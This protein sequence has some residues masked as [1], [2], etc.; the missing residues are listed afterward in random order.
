MQGATPTP[1]EPFRRTG[2]GH[3]LRLTLH[4]VRRELTASHRFTMLG[5]LWPLLRLLAQ[6][7]VLAFVFTRVIDVG[8]D[9]YG[10]FLLI[11]LVAWTWFAG[12]LSAG[13]RS[14]V[15]SPHFVFQP[16]FSL[17]LLPVVAILVAFADVLVALPA[18]IAVLAALGTLEWSAL[19]LP[20]LLAVQLALLAGLALLVSS[21]SVY[22]RDI[23]NLLDVA[24][25]IL[26]Y[27]TPV[28][29]ALRTVPDDWRWLIELNPAGVLIEAYRSALLDGVVPGLAGVGLVAG[30]G[31]LLCAIGLA[32]FRRL[33][34]G[35]VDSL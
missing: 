9:D 3:T 34:P 15:A 21:I 10:A 27:A 11:G 35:F 28:I 17:T 32:T 30:A 19:V 25:T 4:L 13:A 31:L 20:A 2:V 16:G 8:V 33:Q 12:A 29:Y 6:T 22:L 23:P 7:A 14:V 1:E 24:L 18:V 26:F 5:V